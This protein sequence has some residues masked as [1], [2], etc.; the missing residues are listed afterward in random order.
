MLNFTFKQLRYVQAAGRFGSIAAAAADQNISQSSITAAID[1]MESQLGYDLFVR[2]PA[3]GIQPTPAGRDTLALI[4]RFLDT[5]R[6]FESEMGAI[7]GRTTGSIRVGCYATAAPSFLPPIL[8]SWREKYPGVS[9]TLLETDM[10]A[11]V[12]LLDK[13]EID[14]AFT[15][16]QTVETRHRFQPLF[17]APP[18]AVIA[19]D[20]PLA[21]RDSVT[22]ADLS[23]LP[24]VMLDL[25]LA[26][27]YFTSL[28]KARNVTANIGHS[29]RSSEMVRALVACGYG[30][31]ILNIRP[32]DY[33]PGIS[34]YSLVPIVDDLPAPVFG[35]ASQAVSRLP[36]MVQAILT[37]CMD[38][39]DAGAFDPVVVK[40]RSFPGKM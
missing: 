28:F 30:F 4:R 10:S 37:H 21:E 29:S 26:R 39:R 24:M 18:Y 36:G 2:T 22:L 11:M 20:N 34:P 12:G 19:A 32:A 27:A 8:T 5:S 14:F 31:S 1:A 9:V 15:Y 3:R 23:A 38:L 40:P 16:E 35:I 17:A 33:R 6:H 7:G 13:G 25:P